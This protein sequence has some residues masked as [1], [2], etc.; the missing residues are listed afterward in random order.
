LQTKVKATG[1]SKNPSVI[2]GKIVR[3]GLV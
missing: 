1:V 2:A 3:S